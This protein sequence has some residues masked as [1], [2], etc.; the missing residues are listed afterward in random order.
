[1]HQSIRR[2]ALFAALLGA[3][4]ST[5]RPRLAVLAPDPGDL[6]GIWRRQSLL[7]GD[8]L[9]ISA[10]QNGRFRIVL[11][12]HSDIGTLPV[13]ESTG[14]IEGGFLRLDAPMVHFG[15]SVAGFLLVAVHGTVRLATDAALAALISCAAQPRGPALA[16]AQ[17]YSFGRVR[18]PYPTPVGRSPKSTVPPNPSSHRTAYGGR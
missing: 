11:L 16:C 7:E 12:H 3:S 10:L 1:M 15:G 17:D 5:T 13:E 18:V 9:T 4:C 6:V 8:D 14:H 2:A